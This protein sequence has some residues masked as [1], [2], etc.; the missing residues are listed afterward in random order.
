MNLFCPLLVFSIVLLTAVCYENE[1]TR[2]SSQPVE[3]TALSWS[4][5]RDRFL[6]RDLP[7]R[8]GPLFYMY[9][10]PRE[11]RFLKDVQYIS[12]S[13]PYFRQL[14]SNVD[15]SFLPPLGHEPIPRPQ[16]WWR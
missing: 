2:S 4:H 13:S 9:D 3:L 10:L 15:C 12:N 6:S 5:Y 16:F 8:R 7:Q 1:K 11:V 14:F